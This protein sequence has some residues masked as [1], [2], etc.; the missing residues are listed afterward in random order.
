MSV[1][2]F[3]MFLHIYYSNI[4]RISTAYVMLNTYLILILMLIKNICKNYIFFLSVYSKYFMYLLSLEWKAEMFTEA[5][6]LLINIKKWFKI[7]RG[8]KMA[9]PL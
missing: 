7:Y 4:N 3:Y 1:Y 6:D 2:K 5:L 9:E 8:I